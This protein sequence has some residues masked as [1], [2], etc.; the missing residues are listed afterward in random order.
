MF[1]K[2]T[3]ALSGIFICAATTGCLVTD[4]D[5]PPQPSSASGMLTT[6]WTLDGSSDPGVCAFYAIDRVDVVVFNERGRSYVDAQP[7]CEDFGVSFDLPPGLYTNEVTL[8]DFYGNAV[9][10]TV[11]VVD[12]SVRRDTETFVDVDFPDPLIF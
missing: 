11:V 4:R 6:T 1:T 8:L 3:S 5:P 7:F 9:S 10:D 2:L 12:L